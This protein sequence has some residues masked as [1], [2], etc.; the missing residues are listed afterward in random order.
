[1]SLEN[2]YSLVS[3]A[4]RRALDSQE[5]AG[6][7]IVNFIFF[8]E[9][10]PEGLVIYLA[11]EDAKSLETA[12][13]SGDTEQMRR[14]VKEALEEEGYPPWPGTVKFV[15]EQEVNEAGGPWYYFR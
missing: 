1:M 11:Y 15:S 4:V 5:A 13:Q 8:G 2:G 3:R 12:Q 10:K 7:Q 6:P 14:R 9:E